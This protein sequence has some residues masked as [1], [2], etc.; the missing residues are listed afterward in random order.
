M[1]TLNRLIDTRPP[2]APGTPCGQAVA[3]FDAD[4]AMP[5][6]AV[7]ENG[8]PVGLV[9]RDVL[10]GMMRVAGEQLADKPIAEVMD[11]D[12]RIVSVDTATDSF[13]NTLAESALPVFRTAYVAVDAN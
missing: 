11:T 3:M 10:Q 13:V 9:Y 5:A 4:P 7:A 8:V 6:V 1:E 12:P 2:I